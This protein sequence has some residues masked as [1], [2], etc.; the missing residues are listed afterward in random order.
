MGNFIKF[1]IGGLL[2]AGSL[3]FG[4]ALIFGGL[5]TLIARPDSLG[6]LIVWGVIDFIVLLIGVY[7]V[8]R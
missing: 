6:I 2:I 3:L 5:F 1:L 8:R 4:F 7:L